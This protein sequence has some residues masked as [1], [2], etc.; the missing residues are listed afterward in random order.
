MKFLDEEKERF[1]HRDINNNIRPDKVKV[2]L[3]SIKNNKSVILIPAQKPAY[4]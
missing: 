3:G 1:F 2:R 4:Q